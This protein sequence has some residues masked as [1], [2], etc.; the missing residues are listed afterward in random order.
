MLPSVVQA[1]TWFRDLRTEGAARERAASRLHGLLLR[2]ATHEAW[3]RRSS[4]PDTIHDELDDLS[5]QAAS[6]ALMAITRKLDTFRGEARFATWA[7]K[8]AIFELL[9]RAPPPDLAG[10]GS[11][12]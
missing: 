11:G 3:R 12:E 4:I 7:S 2:V 10:S 9:D 6:D 5:H 8:F 1:D